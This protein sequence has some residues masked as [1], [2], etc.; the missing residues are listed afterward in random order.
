M[1]ESLILSPRQGYNLIAPYYDSWKW[2]DFWHSNE[3]PLIQRWCRD[4]VVGHGSDFGAGSGN[5]LRCFLNSGHQVTAYDVS[6]MM[7]FVCQHK[8]VN[9]IESGQLRCIVQDVC[10]L[11]VSNK[12]FDWIMCNR[13]LSHIQD[14]SKLIRRIGRTLK[15]GGECFLSDVHPLHH[16]EHTHFRLG[17]RDVIIETHKHSL[18]EITRQF[19]MNSL[20]ILEFKE[21]RYTDLYDKKTA[22]NLHSI[23]D[24]GTPIFYY[25]RLKKI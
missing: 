25:Y 8:Y 16:Y 1:P 4:M 23:Q 7:L 15:S 10:E 2:Q 12:E 3:Y 21:V 18:E 13:V 22:E 24:D 14:V 6:D 20:K 11:N 17:S 19:F 5:N 9:E